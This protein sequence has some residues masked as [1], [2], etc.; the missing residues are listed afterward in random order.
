MNFLFFLSGT[1][2]AWFFILDRLQTGARYVFHPRTTGVYL[3]LFIPEP[4]PLVRVRSIQRVSHP[5][6]SGQGCSWNCERLGVS[7]GPGKFAIPLNVSMC[8]LCRTRGRAGRELLCSGLSSF[9]FALPLGIYCPFDRN[10]EEDFHHLETPPRQGL[11]L[12]FLTFLGA[13]KSIGSVHITW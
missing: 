2:W 11:V 4:H 7:P 9:L 8:S 3:S 12:F 5:A 6:D 10:C 13:L 1:K